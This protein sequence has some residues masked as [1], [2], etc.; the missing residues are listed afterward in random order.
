MNILN[1]LQNEEVIQYELYKPPGAL[2]DIM[3]DKF[4]KLKETFTEKENV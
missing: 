1:S 3:I 4:N 2:K